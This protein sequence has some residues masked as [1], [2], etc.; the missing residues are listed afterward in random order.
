MGREEIRPPRLLGGDDLI[1]MGFAPGPHFKSILKDVEDQQL[2]GALA[3]RDEAV[4][5]V[6]ARYGPPPPPG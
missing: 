2:D 3:S 6:R 4:D 1:A 5:Y